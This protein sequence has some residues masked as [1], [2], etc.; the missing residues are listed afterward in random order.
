[1]KTLFTDLDNTLIYS[2]RRNISLD[3]ICIERNNDKEIS[4]ITKRSLDYINK[5]ADIIP[6]TTRSLR[7]YNRIQLPK[8]NT[9]LLSNG[10]ILLNNGVIDE[11]WYNESLDYAKRCINDLMLAKRFLEGSVDTYFEVRF[12][13]ELFIFTKVHNVENNMIRLK[14]ILDCNNVDI[15]NQRDK[16]YIFPKELSKG[17]AI[18]RLKQRRKLG[19]IFSAGDAPLDFSMIQESDLFITS[20]ISCD[21]GFD[22]IVCISSNIFFDDVIDYVERVGVNR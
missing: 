16:I 14:S 21:S 15:F 6:L 8:F 22:N 11:S 4:Y 3:M 20:N 18:K 2:S 12:V 10:G 7:Q 19:Y 9:I 17:N 13:D 1:M 5:H